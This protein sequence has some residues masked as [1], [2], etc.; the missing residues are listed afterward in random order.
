MISFDCDNTILYK[1]D[2]SIRK[3]LEECYVKDYILSEVKFK[4][5]KWYPT[6]NIM[7]DINSDKK[8]YDTLDEIIH[9]RK[10]SMMACNYLNDYDLPYIPYVM[11]ED[12]IMNLCSVSEKNLV[13]SL[14]E[15]IENNIKEY[16][17]IKLC[18]LSPKDCGS[19][20]F[21]DANKVISVL[22]QHSERTSDYNFRHL[23]MK[24][25][26]NIIQEFRCYWINDKIRFVVSVN[27]IKE[28]DKLL[29]NEFFKTYKYNLP[30]TVCI[31][32]C[33]SKECDHLEVVEMNPLGT[34]L[35]C[36]IDP[37][38]WDE[39]AIELYSSTKT[40]YRYNYDTYL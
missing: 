3:P 34:D 30:H 31:E 16:P 32:L 11:T 20:I 9:L 1:Y 22:T 33:K 23:I 4:N 18:S 21:T 25:V 6:K 36:G 7:D 12:I 5:E 27:E 38:K 17:F 39:D 40:I 19:C 29:V 2:S 28:E 10:Q 8:C 13:D 35:T 26:R 24:K 15:F 14:K 37:L